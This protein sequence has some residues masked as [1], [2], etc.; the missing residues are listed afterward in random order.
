M[1][2][3]EVGNKF[4]DGDMWTAGFEGMFYY[5]QMSGRLKDW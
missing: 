3:Q 4:G 2:I 1:E 5:W